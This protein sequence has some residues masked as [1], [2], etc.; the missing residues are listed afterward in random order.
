MLGCVVDRV[1]K[2][3]SSHEV[4]RSLFSNLLCNFSAFCLYEASD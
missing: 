4:T 3:V 1:G 2:A